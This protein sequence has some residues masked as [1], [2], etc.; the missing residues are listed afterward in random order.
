MSKISETELKAHLRLAL[1][2][3]GP[4]EPKW[5]DEV[6]EWVFSH[7]KYPVEYGGLSKTE[8]RRNYPKYLREF[9]KQRLNGRLLPELER[10]TK[11]AGGRKTKPFNL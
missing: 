9:I 10:I 5:D 4:I 2:E 3:I 7:P 6:R 1:G 11:G 8:V